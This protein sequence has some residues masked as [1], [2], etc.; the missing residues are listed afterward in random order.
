MIKLK[1]KWIVYLKHLIKLV[2]FF[3][4]KLNHN[5]SGLNNLI[6]YYNIPVKKMYSTLTCIDSYKVS[7]LQLSKTQKNRKII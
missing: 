5:K 7:C 4:S 6:S 2:K 1:V 3:V